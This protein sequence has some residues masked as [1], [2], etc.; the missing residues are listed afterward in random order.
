MKTKDEATKTNEEIIKHKNVLVKKY[1]SFIK[2]YEEQLSYFKNE[3]NSCHKKNICKTIITSVFLITSVLLLT[4]TFRG[5]LKPSNAFIVLGIGLGAFGLSIGQTFF[6]DITDSFYSSIK[7]IQD[8]YNVQENIIKNN[9]FK[10]FINTSKDKDSYSFIWDI[11]YS[12]GF[13]CKDFISHNNG[14][15]EF[16]EYRDSQSIWNEE[17]IDQ[18]THYEEII[19]LSDNHILSV[20][21]IKAHSYKDIKEGEKLR[22]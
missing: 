1:D 8:N 7:V 13:F 9:N 2:N 16:T 15:V 6:D 10:Y 4:F 19:D 5:I 3:Y 21:E 18:K 20:E 14:T 17:N 22:F 11:E 12:Q